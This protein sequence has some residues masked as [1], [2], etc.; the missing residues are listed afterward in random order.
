MENIVSKRT[1][2]SLMQ[3][4]EAEQ[5]LRT[6]VSAHI[7]ALFKESRSSDFKLDVSTNEDAY[8]IATEIRLFYTPEGIIR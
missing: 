5:E 8:H 1:S 4:I 3:V 6:Q 7:R 2:M